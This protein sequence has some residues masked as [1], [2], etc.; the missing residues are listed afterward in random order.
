[1][2][3]IDFIN[4]KVMGWLKAGIVERTNSPYNRQSSVY[5]RN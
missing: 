3:Q 4:E 5:Q 1:M 2:E